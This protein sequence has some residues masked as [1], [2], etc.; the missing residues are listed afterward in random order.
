MLPARYEIVP[1]NEWEEFIAQ[2]IPLYYCAN[3]C[4]LMILQRD[5]RAAGTAAESG[6]HCIAGGA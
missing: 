2:F 4:L 6:A 5:S 1:E 3:V